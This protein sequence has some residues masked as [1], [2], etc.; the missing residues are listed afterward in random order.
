MT[1]ENKEEKC[2]CE[3]SSCKEDC[4]RNHTCKTFWCEKCEP[5]YPP[6]PQTPEWEER[7]ETFINKQ[8]NLTPR[9]IV[10]FKHFLTAEITLAKEEGRRLEQERIKKNFYEEFSGAGELWFDYGTVDDDEYV[11]EYWERVFKE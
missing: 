4:K 2:N 7:Y 10:T 6:T 5:V 1:S 3:E 11:H 9:E 8:V